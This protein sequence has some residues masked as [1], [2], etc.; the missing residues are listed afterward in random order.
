MRT[1][2]SIAIARRS[3]NSSHA[4]ATPP[5]PAKQMF[6]LGMNQSLLAAHPLIQSC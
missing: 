5:F 3:S 6:V 4:K 2:G 1:Y